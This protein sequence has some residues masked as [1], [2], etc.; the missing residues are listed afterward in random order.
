MKRLHYSAWSLWY[1]QTDYAEVDVVVDA[2]AYL[3]GKI[4]SGE[5]HIPDGVSYTLA[6]CYKNQI[7]SE[8]RLMVVLPLA[9]LIIFLILYFQ[10]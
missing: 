1:V 4:K 5:L 3:K 8:K 9:L 6:G 2:Q 7:R 10:F